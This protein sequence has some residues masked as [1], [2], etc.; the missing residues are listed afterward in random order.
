MISYHVLIHIFFAVIISC[1][2]SYI[3]GRSCECAQAASAHRERA[4]LAARAKPKLTS[5][6]DQA[7]PDLCR[8]DLIVIYNRI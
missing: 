6:L 3:F 8:S 7:A 1:M 2:N 5:C 4:A